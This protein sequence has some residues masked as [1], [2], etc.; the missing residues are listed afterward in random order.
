[1]GSQTNVIWNANAGSVGQFAWVRDELMS[2]EGVCFHNTVDMDQ[3]RQA[4]HDAVE[5]NA[6]TIVACGG[7]GTVSLIINT[8]QELQSQA[9]LGVIP[10]GTANELCRS[11]AMPVDPTQAL[12]VIDHGQIRHIDLAAIETPEMKR[13]F[14]NTAGGGNS[15][16]VLTE[17]DPE[18]K[19]EWR[20]WSY[21]RKG[22]ELLSDLTTYDVVIQCDDGPEERFSIWNLVVANGRTAGGGLAVAP[23]ANL[24]DGWLD[25]VMVLDGEPLDVAALGAKI[26]IGGYLADE[27]TVFRRAKKVTVR[28]DP[29]MVFIADG[30]VLEGHPG[31]FEVLPAA[32]SVFVGPDYAPGPASV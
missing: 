18:T 10:L 17:L 14:S 23:E 29:P 20:A 11:L 5:S 13:Y 26:L 25:I 22:L 32:L 24:E 6:E 27:R 30:E 19:K 15:D 2:R 8:M 12:R 3:A 7:D 4:V 31:I 21:M 1:M 16:R 28:S 9:T